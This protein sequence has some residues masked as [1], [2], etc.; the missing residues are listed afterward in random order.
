MFIAIFSIFFPEKDEFCRIVYLLSLNLLKTLD[1]WH[2]AAGA[3][4]AVAF[5]KN[6][7]VE[8]FHLEVN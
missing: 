7:A 6:E 2:F 5:E 8:N 3:Q 4:I 1:T